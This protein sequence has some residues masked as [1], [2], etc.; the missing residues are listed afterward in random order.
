FSGNSATGAQVETQVCY[1]VKTGAVVAKVANRGA[2]AASVALQA[3]A[4]RTDGPWTL[5]VPA[6]Q[7]AEQSWALADSG[8]WYDFTLQADGWE[9]RFAGRVETGKHTVSD[10]AMG[11]PT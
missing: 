6:G 2:A 11:I 5:D 3:N 7:V 1:D 10:P 9:R 4:Y 8:N